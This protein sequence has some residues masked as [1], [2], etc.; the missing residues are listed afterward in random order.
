MSGSTVTDYESKIPGIKVTELK[1]LLS[2]DANEGKTVL[3]VEGSDDRTFYVRYV[4]EPNV[5]FSVLNSCYYMPDILQRTNADKNLSDRVIGI[6]DADFDRI[7]G[8][9]TTSMDNLFLTDTHDWET[10]TQ[11]EEC[12]RNVSIEALG[13]T[14]AGVFCKVM[15]DLKNYSYLKLYNIAEICDKSKEGISFKN[16]NIAK[17]YNGNDA[18]RVDVCL[19]KV[20]DHNNN[21]RLAHFPVEADIDS[22]K[23]AYPH[24]DLLQF[25]CGHDVIQAVVQ[26]MIHLKGTSTEVGEK[27]TARIFRAT[28]TKE[29]FKATQL[30]KDVAQWAEAH[31]AVV[32]AA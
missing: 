7:L 14:E 1:Q 15:D 27:E 23:T 30:Y 16:F 28:F 24:P 13:H 8:K 32:W 26:R 20:K 19:E 10:M 9:P 12:E 4:S 22:I 29:M 31:N 6:K 17:V 18:C 11:T 5:V 3:L 21:S 25:T 2:N